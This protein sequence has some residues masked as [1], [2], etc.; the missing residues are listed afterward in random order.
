MQGHTSLP[1]GDDDHYD[2]QDGDDH[3]DDDH[4]IMM[5]MM[6][7]TMMDIECDSQSKHCCCTFFLDFALGCFAL[8]NLHK[9]QSQMYSLASEEILDI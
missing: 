4:T 3:S 9:L 6:G 7:M 5:A 8:D 2:D 1:R